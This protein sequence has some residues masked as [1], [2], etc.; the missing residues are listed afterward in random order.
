MD[1]R[2][3]PAGPAGAKGWRSVFQEG[4]FIPYPNQTYLIWAAFIVLG[5]FVAAVAIEVYRRKRERGKRIDAEWRAVAQIAS[6][7]ELS[8]RELKLLSTLIKQHA[9][10]APLRTATERQRFDRC[11]IQEMAAYAR[12]HDEAAYEKHG[13]V[14][15]DVR[16]HLG[17]DYIPYG[18]R[19]HSTRDL[20][21]G[22]RVW[23]APADDENSPWFVMLVVDVDEARFHLSPQDRPPAVSPGEMLRCRLCRE[24]D[25]RYRFT[26]RLLRYEEDGSDWVMEHTEDVHRI[27]TRAHFRIHYER[28]LPVGILNAPVDG[29]LTNLNARNPVTRLRGRLTN[30]SGGGFAVVLP[31]AVPKQVFLRVPLEVDEHGPL[32]AN[33]RVVETT[34]MA[35]GRHLVRAAFVALEDEDRERITQFVFHQ[36]QPVQAAETAAG[37]SVE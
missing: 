22:Q 31:Q 20:T 2:V 28:T 17:H 29:D 27:Q 24:E 36:Q 16:V 35:T 8:Q 33:A 11:V 19:I 14:L 26:V 34:P 1:F 5:L 30:L 37:Q 10:D 3:I 9:P 4:F 13:Q 7:K 18:Q 12:H 25:A 21:A 23:S 32:A 6:E 15:R